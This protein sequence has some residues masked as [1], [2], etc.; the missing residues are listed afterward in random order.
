M[1]ETEFSTVRFH[2]DAERAAEV[3]AGVQPLTADD[4][5]DCI[6]WAV[7][8]PPHVDVDLLVVRP[9]A[10]AAAH[11]VARSGDAGAIS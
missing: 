4:I 8:R 7:T 1:V 3:Y 11:L 10:Q 2:G 5:A 9:V 6:V